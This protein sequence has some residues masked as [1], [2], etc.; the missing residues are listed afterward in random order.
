VTIDSV[1]RTGVGVIKS[2]INLCRI[3]T[4]PSYVL[5]RRASGF[6]LLNLAVQISETP[7]RMSVVTRGV[8]SMPTWIGRR[9]RTGYASRAANR[10]SDRFALFET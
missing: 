3:M 7:R 1:L 8:C 2:C 5:V 6:S 10:R 9:R 4:S